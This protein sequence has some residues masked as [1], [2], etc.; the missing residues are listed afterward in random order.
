MKKPVAKVIPL[1]NLEPSIPDS[2]QA[3]KR[4]YVTVVDGI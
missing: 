4:R 1:S 2:W 3:K